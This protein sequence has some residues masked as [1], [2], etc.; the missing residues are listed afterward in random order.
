MDILY[1]RT[2]SLLE[3]VHRHFM[4]LERSPPESIALVEQDL[5][6]LLDTI[7]ENCTKLD[8]LVNKEIPSR[9]V[10]AR[11]QVDQ[12]KYDFRHFQTSLQNAIHR[13]LVREQEMK[14]R[15][16]LLS[17]RFSPNPQNTTIMIDTSLQTN[18]SL[19]NANRG[20]N[21]LLDS[22]NSMLTNLREQKMSLKG[23]HKKIL[24]IANTLGLSN[25]VMRLIE[26]RTY[27]DKYILF[28]GMILTCFFMFVVVKYLT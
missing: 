1:H 3:E 16:E 20:I 11:V 5:Q 9:R 6:S 22:G 23:A 10:A 17:Q 15:E 26:K 2:S 25:T 12:L 7:N 14:E 27:Q 24:D 4:R 13:R 18:T 8:I 21:E 28:G 19:Q